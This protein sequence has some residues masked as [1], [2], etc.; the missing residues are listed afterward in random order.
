MLHITCMVKIIGMVES[1]S[2]QLR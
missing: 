1:L 2:L